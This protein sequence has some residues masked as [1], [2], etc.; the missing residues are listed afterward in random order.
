MNNVTDQQIQLLLL[1]LHKA[2]KAVDVWEY[3]LPLWDSD[4]CVLAVRKWLANINAKGE[5]S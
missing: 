2:A 4:G 3:G 1:E 5:T